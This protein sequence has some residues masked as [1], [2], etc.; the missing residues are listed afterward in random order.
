MLILL[1]NAFTVIQYTRHDTWTFVDDIGKKFQS[2]KNTISSVNWWF[3]NFTCRKLTTKS[4]D[5]LVDL[6]VDMIQGISLTKI[7]ASNN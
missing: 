3:P 2:N 1:E 6:S 4:F 5:D 7:N